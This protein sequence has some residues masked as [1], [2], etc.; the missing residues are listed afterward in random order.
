MNHAA[1]VREVKNMVGQAT[2]A[3]PTDAVPGDL[4]QFAAAYSRELAAKLPWDELDK[5]ERVLREHPLGGIGCHQDQPF[6]A[7][8]PDW[9]G[10]KVHFI[11]R[12]RKSEGGYKLDLERPALGTSNRFARRFGSRRFVRVRIPEDIVLGGDGDAL[13]EFFKRPFVIGSAVFRAFYAKE[14]NVFLFRTNEEVLGSLEEGSLQVATAPP[15]SATAQREHSFLSLIKWHNDLLL[16]SEQTMV[17]WAARFALGLSN[18]VPGV[19]LKP[20]NIRFVD[21]VVCDAF[22]GGGKPP[23]EMQMT[24]GCGLANRALMRILEARFSTWRDEPTAIQCRIGGAKG[25]LCM[26]HDLSAD[27]E[28]EP[29]IWLR[30]SQ[31][32]IKHSP[33]A[34]HERL[35]PADA[36]PALLTID[37]LRASRM[38]TP[39]HLSVETII[40][41]AENGVPH[42]YFIDL[43]KARLTERLDTLLLFD[44]NDPKGMQRLWNAIAREGGVISARMA[45]EAAGIARA[46]G[47]VAR[48]YDDN[49]EELEDEDELDGVGRALRD[50]SSAWWEDPVSGSPSALEETCLVLLDSGF[51]PQTCPVLRAKLMEVAK[52]VVASLKTKYRSAVPM[53]CSAFIVPDP[54]GVLGPNEIHVKCSRRDFID[55]DG[56]KTDIVLGDVLVTRHPCKVPSDVQK[57]KAV[58]HEK[59]RHYCDVIVV[60][61]KS[62]LFQGESLNRHLA[63][64]T[65]GGDYDGDTMEVF[66]DP[67]LVNAFV[68]PDPR[69]FAVEPPQVQKCLIENT[70][71]VAAFLARVPPDAPEDYRISTMQS[72]LLG[73]LKGGAYVSTYSIWWEKS[74][75]MN[76]YSHDET[77]F[78]AYMFCAILDGSK[79]GVTVRPE[80]FAKH[81]LKWGARK[82]GWKEEANDVALVPRNPSLRRFIMDVLARH[83]RKACDEQRARIDDVLGPLPAVVLDQDLARPFLEAERSA[84]ALKADGEPSKWNE[85]QQIKKHVQAVHAKLSEAKSGSSKKGSRSRARVSGGGPGGSASLGGGSGGAGAGAGKSPFTDLPIERRQDILRELSR[86]FHAGPKDLRCFDDPTAIKASYAYLYDHD[87]SNRRGGWTR[88]PW[89]VALRA[90]CEIKVKAQGNYKPLSGDFYP[91]MTISPTY[92]R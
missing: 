90:L 68:P 24:D 18:S 82:L 77:V 73:A 45:R 91:W 25:L 34:L 55:Q 42:S 56:R 4:E 35:L 60:S 20:E 50:Q 58:F 5:E 19:R 63:S 14:K 29:I 49:P 32:K 28:E 39:A 1:V 88:F 11:A 52:K 8:D 66:W 78:L 48:D 67:A 51:V 41:L 46:A 23:S 15:G 43:F 84:L 27:E 54:H 59:L 38:N 61:T 16:N 89:D 9:Y 64:L 3:N 86:Q 75:Y 40:N 80:E 2:K 87:R 71:S 13:V 31:I 85:L 72:Y 83:V 53:S 74:T 81:R 47:L 30:P 12:L 57:V 17:K 33:Y 69:K 37:L 7:D 36:D 76:G 26:Y 6:C 22:T 21:D 44:G 65:G 70:E 10:G 92:L 62:H 79:T